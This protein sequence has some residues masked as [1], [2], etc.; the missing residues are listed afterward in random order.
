MPAEEALGLR[1]RKKLDTRMALSDAALELAFERGLDN[2]TR[3]D[4][5]KRAGVSV[6]TFNNYFTGKYDAITYRQS[7]RIRRS[8]AAFRERPA[9]EPLWSALTAALLEPLEAEQ[10]EFRVPTAAQLAEVRKLFRAPELRSALF[11][12]VSEDWLELIAERTGT[13]PLHDVYPRLVTGMIGTVID[14]AMVAYAHADP[15]VPIAPLL[16]R[17]LD[18][19]TAGLPEPPR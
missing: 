8:L 15:P 4:I 2:V 16:R 9:D 6:R 17:A 10:A 14:A 3:E 13:D 1:E 11:T 5:A 12:G 7:V 18:Q 19:V